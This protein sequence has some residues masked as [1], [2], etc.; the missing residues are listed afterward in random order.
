[1]IKCKLASDSHPDIY[2]LMRVNVNIKG[3]NQLKLISFSLTYFLSLSL[4]FSSV[5]L[6]QIEEKQF[7]KE[8]IIQ[9]SLLSLNLKLRKYIQTMDL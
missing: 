8:A 4:S 6:S 5:H 2:K 1:M 9:N 7:W 3:N